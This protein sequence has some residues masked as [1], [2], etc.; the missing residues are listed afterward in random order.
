MQNQRFEPTGLATAGKIH[1]LPGEGTGF[2]C[3]DAVDWMFGLVMDQTLPFLQSIPRPLA[4]YSA[5]LLTLHP[6]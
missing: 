1:Q 6:L 3:H 5:P 4:I 2:T